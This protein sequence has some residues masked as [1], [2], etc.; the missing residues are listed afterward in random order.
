MLYI[1]SKLVVVRD[2]I[3]G[4]FR[5]SGLDS[6]F[7]N[8]SVICAQK[9]RT[10]I[11]PRKGE[12][13]PMSRFVLSLWFVLVFIGCASQQK[14][15]Q[16][17]AEAGYKLGRLDAPQPVVEGAPEGIPMQPLI[18]VKDKEDIFAEPGVVVKGKRD[19]FVETDVLVIRESHPILYLKGVW[20]GDAHLESKAFGGGLILRSGQPETFN[21]GGR[22]VTVT[23]FMIHLIGLSG[24]GRYPARIGWGCTDPEHWHGSRPARDFTIVVEG[25]SPDSVDG[26]GATDTTGGGTD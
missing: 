23:P 5:A 10:H 24:P 20:T 13:V 6:L 19:V 7:D 12:E 1:H 9:S 17:L 3:H 22:E 18:F 8:S 16:T 15:Q 4:E 26:D 21:W 14:P 2:P 25:R 11:T